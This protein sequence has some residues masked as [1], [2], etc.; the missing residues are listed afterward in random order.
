[1][2]FEEFLFFICVLALFFLFQGDPDIWDLLQ[3][4]VMHLLQ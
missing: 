4:K 2:D 1:M 3:A